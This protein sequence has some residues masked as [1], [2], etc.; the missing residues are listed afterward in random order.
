MNYNFD[1]FGRYEQPNLILC[2]T[3]DTEI[4]CIANPQDLQVSYKNSDVS[5]ITYSIYYK[6]ISSDEDDYFDNEVYDNHI[7]RRQVHVI[8]V[9]YFIITSVSESDGMKGRCKQITAKSCEYE[10][11]NVSMPYINGTYALYKAENF[12][13]Q[14]N[15]NIAQQGDDYMNANC[16][17]YEVMKCIPSWSLKQIDFVEK[18][19]YKELADTF[20]TFEY[21]SMS[22]YS[23]LK[24]VIQDK[25][26]CY[27]S[28]DIETRTIEILRRDDVFKVLPA[29][30]SSANIL[31]ECTV[32]TD[33]DDYVNSLRVEIVN[34]VSI[35]PFNPMG[36]AVIYNFDHDI[37]SGLI[38]GELKDALEFWKQ[39]INNPNEQKVTFTIPK[40]TADCFTAWKD[41][42]KK[43][44]EFK[45]R[46]K[47]KI[48][49][50]TADGS[51]VNYSNI[52]S[53][54]V[55]YMTKTIGLDSK[56]YVPGGI[57]T[58]DGKR[59]N[60]VTITQA[61]SNGTC[62]NAGIIERVFFGV[63]SRKHELI[64]AK[65]LDDKITLSLSETNRQLLYMQEYLELVT[66]EL[67]L[68]ESN[69]SGYEAQ[70]TSLETVTVESDDNDNATALAFNKT[71]VNDYI[72]LTNKSIEYYNQIIGSD[73][74]EA[75]ASGLSGGVKIIS[76]TV[77]EKYK[78]NS[79]ERAF[80]DFTGDVERGAELYARLTRYFKQQTYREETIVI[81]EAMGL[82]E[83]F[84]QSGELYRQAVDTLKTI[85][86]PKY[87]MSIK[88]ESFLLSKEFADIVEQLTMRSAI[89][90]EI[91]NGDVPLFMLESLNIKYDSSD[92]EITFGNRI[93]PSDPLS[94]FTDLQNTAISTA[95][96]VAAE[97]INWGISS[98]KINELMQ[99]K[100]A[101]INTTYREMTNSI[102]S[103]TTGSY[104]FKCFT[105]DQKYGIWMANGTAMFIEQDENGNPKAKAAIGRIIK[106]NGDV[107]Y[108]FYGQSLIANSVTADKLMAGTLSKGTNYVRNG[109]FEKTGEHWTLPTGQSGISQTHNAPVGQTYLW[110]NSGKVATQNLTASS[111]VVT[112][113][114]YVLSFYCRRTTDGKGIDGLNGLKININDGADEIGSCGFT[115]NQSAFYVNKDVDGVVKQNYWARCYKVFKI[116]DYLKVPIIEISNETPY[117]A[118]IDGV[119]LEKAVDLNDYTPHI[120]ETYAKYTTIDDSGITV[121]DGKISILNKTGVRVFGA[122]DEGNLSLVG[123]ITAADGNIGGWLI[124][125][126]SLSYGTDA[127]GNPTYK[128]G[129]SVKDGDPAFWSGYDG[130]GAIADKNNTSF[131]VTKDGKIS[132]KS[133]EIGGWT[134]DTTKLYNG[135]TGMSTSG[136]YV[137][138]A[139]TSTDYNFKVNQNGYL[140]A[141]NAEIDKKLTLKNGNYTM[142]FDGYSILMKYGGSSDYSSAIS[143]ASTSDGLFGSNTNNANL[144]IAGST[145]ILFGTRPSGSWRALCEIEHSLS[146]NTLNAFYFQPSNGLMNYAYLGSST[147]RWNDLYLNGLTSISGVATGS[148]KNY[149]NWC[150]TKIN[151]LL[152]KDFLD[153]ILGWLIPG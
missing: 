110:L 56:V 38:A 90:A 138:Y 101:D 122:D 107:E 34:D 112:P 42:D 55:T 19:E 143:F 15:E 108:G 104:G 41:Y 73:G 105:E 86:E 72:M 32:S 103:V 17:L 1:Y 95:S 69:L 22:V 85:S 30:L 11:N 16:I 121:Y 128:C 99:A 97:R 49:S 130:S 116:G 10:L 27:V 150:E 146:S 31:D 132:A 39:R 36:G 3:D 46:I 5:E 135:N 62:D 51:N 88:V 151:Y 133:G 118:C 75:E 125:P 18:E 54:L 117:S 43:I 14:T 50:D 45:N 126:Q 109:S 20:R 144:A 71:L 28:F 76:S 4:G 94:V 82:D 131:F 93:N 35:A 120:S 12:S 29:I 24:S 13:E 140:F 84:D 7:E 83:K 136:T 58:K 67:S 91:P 98:E 106:A 21:E 96:V 78:T 61:L 47:E 79:F 87:E 124:K 2:N 100:A 80:S 123:T 66:S 127:N 119:M 81:T 25:Y 152:S 33:I 114:T 74:S 149:I 141:R 9:G 63:S 57:E 8:G 60:E 44:L 147:R 68:E 129:M 89:Y 113:G 70:L 77:Q 23:F 111:V 53:E 26:S 52:L 145:K 64:K 6:D 142:E 37:N 153:S 92:C 137:F 40:Y 148:V 65:D 115:D 134:I 139:G 102:N 59:A 48:V